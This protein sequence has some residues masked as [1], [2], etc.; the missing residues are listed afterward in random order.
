[1]KHN[2]NNCEHFVYEKQKGQKK[3]E[4]ICSRA[5]VSN[6]H[7]SLI[8]RINKQYHQHHSI[9]IYSQ[10]MLNVWKHGDTMRRICRIMWQFVN[11]LLGT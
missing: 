3:D 7:F 5:C 11:D 4:D 6:N 10:Y 8:H 9:V 1:M 2:E